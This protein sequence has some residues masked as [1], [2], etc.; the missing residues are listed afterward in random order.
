MQVWA[1]DSIAVT[2]LQAGWMWGA[3]S[4]PRTSSLQQAPSPLYPQASPSMA[5]RYAAERPRMSAG[6]TIQLSV[7]M[8]SLLSLSV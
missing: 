3:Q 8:E 2:D 5:R 1:C 7:S 4:Q 6:C